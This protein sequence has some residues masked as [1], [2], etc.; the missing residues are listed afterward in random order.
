[1][2]RMKAPGQTILPVIAILVAVI[3]LAMPLSGCCSLLGGIERNESQETGVSPQE[4]LAQHLSELYRNVGY[5]ERRIH[6]LIN[7][8]RRKQ[9]LS[10]LEWDSRLADIAR[11]HSKDMAER[12]Y[13]DHASPEG[14]D[15]AARYDKFGYK[16]ETRVGNVVYKG[17]ENL[18]LNN[19]VES[20]VYDRETGEVVE[21]RFNTIEDLA[22]DTVQGWMESPGHRENILTPYFKREGIGIV[23]TGEGK[24]YI[25][26]N[27]C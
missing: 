7:E 20:Y 18:F 2:R 16:C 19:L 13:F 15:F 26:E 11:Y 12:N 6:D 17:G 9:G 24:V 27:F 25:T 10:S 14:E 22:K 23:V 5:L 3:L 4:E 21:Y 8:E 1:M